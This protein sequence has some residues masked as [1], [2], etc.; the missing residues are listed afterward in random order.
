[1]VS[2]ENLVKFEVLTTARMK[3]SIFRVT[4][5]YV[6]VEEYHRF[7]GYLLPPSSVP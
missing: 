5:P 6:L 2:N 1:M 4:A 7:K 3:I